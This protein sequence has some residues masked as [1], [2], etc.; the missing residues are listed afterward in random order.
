MINHAFSINH[1]AKP[2]PPALEPS[3]M[4]DFNHPPKP[5]AP[6]HHPTLEEF[7][8]YHGLNDPPAP[9]RAKRPRRQRRNT[10][11]LEAVNLDAVTLDATTDTP[12]P[13]ATADNTLDTAVTPVRPTPVPLE[14][15]IAMPNGGRAARC[16]ATSKRTSLQ[17]NAP[18]TTGYPVCK[19]HGA[20]THKRVKSGQRYDPRDAGHVGS[21]PHIN[22]PQAVA[23]RSAAKHDTATNNAA[24]HGD[25][26]QSAAPYGAAT[27]SAAI[28]SAAGRR[29]SQQR[30]AVY[31][32]SLDHATQR[33]LTLE[34]PDNTDVE[35]AAVRA[36]MWKLIE[37]SGVEDAARLELEHLQ[38][39]LSRA[40]IATPDDRRQLER[41]MKQIKSLHRRVS[42]YLERVQRAGVAV[43]KVIESRSK[44]RV[45]SLQVKLL[46][47]FGRWVLLLRDCLWEALRNQKEIDKFEREVRERVLKDLPLLIEFMPLE[48]EA[49]NDPLEA[50]MKGSGIDELI[51][52][53]V[54]ADLAEYLEANVEEYVEYGEIRIK[55]KRS[56][57]KRWWRDLKSCAAP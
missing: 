55:V 32:S 12:Q 2:S 24:T 46:E 27:P 7:F 31:D 57:L 1:L 41:L 28:Q 38:R 52:L 13:H 16:H 30:I 53:E 40:I 39:E 20:G 47:E 29:A 51:R 45:W 19:S 33:L 10:D 21:G 8:E 4:S 35:L 14:A 49:H 11:D 9:T 18:V 26:A 17:C 23:Q 48:G 15:W 42:H 25:V 6:L 3:G 36:V 34:D 54:V 5:R 22:V 44:T 43:V 56:D 37:Q 50:H